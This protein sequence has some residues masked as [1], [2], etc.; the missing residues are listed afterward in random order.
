MVKRLIN[1]DHGETV[2]YCDSKS[3]IYLTKDQMYHED[4]AH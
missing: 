2:V 1:L 4:K 3:V